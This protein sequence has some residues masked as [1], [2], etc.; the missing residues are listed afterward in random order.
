MEAS[1]SSSLQ[2]A[3]RSQ[4]PSIR[5]NVSVYFRI[6][7]HSHLSLDLLQIR[8]SLSLWPSLLCAKHFAGI[9][10]LC[11][12]R[13]WTAEKLWGRGRLPDSVAQHAQAFVGG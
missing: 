5:V 4:Q 6:F 11:V 12:T 8:P 13:S 7:E 2:Q 10:S 3:P 1:V 9:V